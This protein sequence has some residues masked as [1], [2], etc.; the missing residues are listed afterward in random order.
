MSRTTAN[1]IEI[2]LE[3]AAE[4]IEEAR[5]A[6]VAQDWTEVVRA[7][8]F[9]RAATDEAFDGLMKAAFRTA[10]AMS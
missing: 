3:E 5:Q 6:L 9:A 7:A 8:Y 1:I 2:G 4:L 10:D